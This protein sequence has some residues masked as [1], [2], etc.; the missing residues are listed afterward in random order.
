MKKL[1]AVFLAVLTLFSVGAISSSA[2]SLDSIVRDEEIVV[3][4]GFNKKNADYFEK[5]DA[6]NPSLEF[7]AEPNKM[8]VIDQYTG[9]LTFATGLSSREYGSKTVTVYLG[10]ETKEIEV[11]ALY[12]WYE[13]FV[14]VFAA[15]LFWISSVNNG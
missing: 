6:A 3:F 4:K 5:L 1:L 8:F 12:E 14:I 13:Y 15:G 7:S 2:A 9:K 10:E 11:T